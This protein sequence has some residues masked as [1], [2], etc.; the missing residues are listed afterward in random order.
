[1]RE[2]GAIHPI[3]TNEEL[4]ATLLKAKSIAYSDS[5]S[6]VYISSQLFKKLG[7]EEAVAQKAHKV[8][9]IP[10]ASEAAKGHYAVGIQPAGSRRRNGL[11]PPRWRP[12]YAPLYALSAP[13]PLR[14]RVS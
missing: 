5:A 9:R 7:I 13:P 3:K 1:M 8:E 11:L 2:P 10:V 4:R 12:E 6:G 14:Y